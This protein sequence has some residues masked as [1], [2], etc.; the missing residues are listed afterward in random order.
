[1]IDTATITFIKDKFGYEPSKEQL[2]GVERLM[3]GR[4]VLMSASAGSGKTTACSMALRTWL[5]DR[6]Q[7]NIPGK[8]LALAYTRRVVGDFEK[9]V[10]DLN[11]G[12]DWKDN[13]KPVDTSTAHSFGKQLLS[14]YLWQRGGKDGQ[15]KVKIAYT[16]DDE[17]GKYDLLALKHL[18]VKLGQK[19]ETINGKTVW[20]KNI[21]YE[22]SFIAQAVIEQIISP[23]E[24]RHIQ[25]G[26]SD[27][28]RDM[29]TALV[30]YHG[31]V[32]H[33]AAPAVIDII[34]DQVIPDMLVE[35]WLSFLEGSVAPCDMIAFPVGLKIDPFQV[36]WFKDYRL[37][38]AD[39]VQDFSPARKQLLRLITA[40][41]NVQ[42]IAA[43]DVEQCIYGWAGAD[44]TSFAK[45]KNEFDCDLVFLSTSYR[46]SKAVA[47]YARNYVPHFQV[48]DNAAEGKVERT[49]E[50]AVSMVKKGLLGKGD[51]IISRKK[52]PL[53]EIA[54]DLIRYNS[55]NK[56]SSVPITL[57]GIDVRKELEEAVRQMEYIWDVAKKDYVPKWM[58]CDEMDNFR[59]EVR[60]GNAW[61]YFDTLLTLW[62]ITQTNRIKSTSKDELIEDQRRGQLQDKV[63]IA[64]ICRANSK[65]TN[66]KQFVEELSL[67]F[68]DATSD[69]KQSLKLM[70]I[71]S[72]KGAEGRNVFIANSEDMFTPRDEEKD[73]QAKERRNVCYVAITRAKENVYLHMKSLLEVVP[74]APVAWDEMVAEKS[75][76]DQAMELESLAMREDMNLLDIISLDDLD[77]VDVVED[78]ALPQENI[79]LLLSAIQEKSVGMTVT[80][81]SQILRILD[82]IIVEETEDEEVPV[83]KQQSLW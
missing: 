1:M 46:C 54:F 79:N 38:V 78:I 72:A 55:E 61:D 58:K 65:A 66:F 33:N 36:P 40:K 63:E 12:F 28:V 32:F 21:A 4:N 3:A 17:S 73:W 69:A 26:N 81:L 39:E 53:V 75:K 68:A 31:F 82:P 27:W 77:Q 9:E 30:E 49:N 52:A 18:R 43:G 14:S 2:S 80:Q 20:S 16:R 67:F 41:P 50:P 74:I 6:Q 51:L 5:R 25:S 13:R 45:I 24:M 64:A 56:F 57:H 47:S 37:V 59:L 29:A 22:T 76:L 62:H 60:L 70:S 11:A 34:C 23:I 71:H 19:F 15:G 8:I 10:S 7:R 42:F 35:G 48:P 83:E 44:P